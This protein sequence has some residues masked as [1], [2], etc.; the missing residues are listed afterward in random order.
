MSLLE[1]TLPLDASGNSQ[2]ERQ[3]IG[4]RWVTPGVSGVRRELIGRIWIRATCRLTIGRFKR[5]ALSSAGET[6]SRKKEEKRG[7]VPES[8]SGNNFW[9]IFVDIFGFLGISSTKKIEQAC[10]DTGSALRVTVTVVFAKREWWKLS[11]SELRSIVSAY[12]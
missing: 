9:I 11:T 5:G 10:T 8:E 1:L 6:I 12:S 7:S 3:P 4:L 2:T